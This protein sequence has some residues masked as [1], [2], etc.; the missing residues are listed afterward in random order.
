MDLTILPMVKSALTAGG[1]E[2]GTGL[3]GYL[4][5]LITQYSATVQLELNRKTEQT[6]RTELYDHAAGQRYTYLYAYPVLADPVVEVRTSLDGTFTDDPVSDISIDYL[7]GR[8]WW[9][10]ALPPAGMGTVQVKYAGGMAPNTDAFISAYPD[11]ALAID[12]QITY[13]YQ[14]KDSLGSTSVSI[15]G[16]SI[17]FQSAVEWI[18]ALKAMIDKHKRILY[19]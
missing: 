16:G 12:Q 2:I 13:F 3:N 15:E 6:E 7:E 17:A 8:I 11:I 9:R 18:P 5:D 1:V 4:Q 19:V 10:G 14:R